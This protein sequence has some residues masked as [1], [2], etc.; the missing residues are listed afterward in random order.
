MDDVKIQF[1]EVFARVKRLV[2]IMIGTSASII[3]MFDVMVKRM[4]LVEWRYTWT[5]CGYTR[6]SSGLSV[7]QRPPSCNNVIAQNIPFVKNVERW[8]R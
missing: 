7:Q 5:A 1:R 2:A 6:T 3:A 8:T 4:P